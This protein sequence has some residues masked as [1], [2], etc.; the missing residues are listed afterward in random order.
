MYSHE[1]LLFTPNWYGL[2]GIGYDHK[3]TANQVR[4][5][6]KVSAFKKYRLSGV[7]VMRESTVTH[8]NLF[9][10]FSSP[11]ARVLTC[12]HFSG[13]TV[14]TKEETNWLWRYIHD[15][16]FN[17][18]E[19]LVFL[20]DHECS[21][22][23]KYLFDD[24]NPFRSQHSWIQSSFDFPLIKEGIKYASETDATIPS[25]RIENVIHQSITDIMKSMFTDSVFFTFHMTPF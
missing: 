17:P 12:W 18:S 25:L 19:E 11:T 5:S 10:V 15:P 22:I 20:L 21:H 24:S 1:L 2:S 7:L 16:A 3:I 9:S 14:K 6:K 8:E 13:S 4:K 23:K